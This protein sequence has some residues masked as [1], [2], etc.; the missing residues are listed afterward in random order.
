MEIVLGGV[1]DVAG[2]VVPWPISW[3]FVVADYGA[4]SA[5]ARVSGLLLDTAFAAFQEKD[6]EVTN[7]RQ[8]IASFLS[9]AQ[10]RITNVQAVSALGGNATAVS[11]TIAAPGV[12]DTKTAVDAAQAFAKECAKAN[13]G[14]SGSL[15][16]AMS[17]KVID[18]S[19]STLA[20]IIFEFLCRFARV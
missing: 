9:I 5:S 11:F 13:P 12:G 8:A 20:N 3:S 2:N 18:T 19:A 15:S 14:F 16:T 10:D 7:V 17:S 1:A 6:G 4:D